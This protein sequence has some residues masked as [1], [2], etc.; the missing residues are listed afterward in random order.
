MV[1][2][3]YESPRRRYSSCSTQR[4]A[5]YV[6]ALPRVGDVINVPIPYNV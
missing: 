4:A 5:S 1:G 2:V 3:G 6:H